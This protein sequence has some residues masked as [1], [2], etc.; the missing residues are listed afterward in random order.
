MSSYPSLS[1][2]LTQAAPLDISAA[3]ATEVVGGKPIDARR[4][5]T[6]SAQVRVASLAGAGDATVKLQVSDVLDYTNP[7]Y[8]FPASDADADWVDVSGA[9]CTLAIDGTFTFS[10]NS[11]PQGFARLLFTK[12]GATAGSVEVFVTCKNG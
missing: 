2:E 10:V 4:L 5:S 8:P 7:A 11:L 9:T 12:N 1:T 3:G 6:F